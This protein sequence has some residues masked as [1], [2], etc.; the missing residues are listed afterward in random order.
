MNDRKTLIAAK[1]K[2]RGQIADQI[3]QYAALLE[4]AI[5]AGDAKQVRENQAEI[6]SREAIITGIDKAIADLQAGKS[7][8][9]I[10]AEL[11][12]IDGAVATVEKTS[13]KLDEHMVKKVAP[14]IA[15]LV[16]ALQGAH[17]IATER[18]DA[19]YEITGRMS[20][21]ESRSLGDLTKKAALLDT[22]LAAAI[23][24]E[25]RR[26]GVFST[27][28]PAHWIK[29]VRHDLPPVAEVVSY[30]SNKLIKQAARAAEI[31]RAG[32]GK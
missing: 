1:Q 26:A 22:T 9:D 12:T 32:V 30:A 24:D 28:A 20:E 29:F 10:Q 7:A 15:Q 18:A 25:F 14:A 19:V 8:E 4:D 11:A 3:A 5:Q 13:A 21:R 16:A 31:A 17:A 2:Q 23:E 27:L 6:A